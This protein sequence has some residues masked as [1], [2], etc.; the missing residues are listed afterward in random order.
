[1]IR[2]AGLAVLLMGS[3]ALSVSASAAER[4]YTVTD[5]DRIEVAGPYAVTVTS[6]KGASVRASAEANALDAVKVEVRGRLLSIRQSR[7]AAQGWTVDRAKGPVTI[8]VT[9]PALQAATLVGSG[10][11]S[12]DRLKGQR[13]TANLIGSGELKIVS[14]TSDMLTASASGGGVL[15]IAGKVQMATLRNTGASILDA[16]A[17]TVADATINARS[18]GNLHVLVTRAAKVQASGS[19][20]VIVDGGPA[21]TVTAT[22]TGTVSCGD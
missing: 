15:N 10:K 20:D 6:G 11:L 21:C 17:L 12:V 9:V 2:H 19:G 16:A 3:A 22:G 13:I 14:A 7:T 4:G 18:A 1:L 5:F 8:V